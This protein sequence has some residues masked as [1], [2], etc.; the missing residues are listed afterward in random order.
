VPGE[1]AGRLRGLEAGVCSTT[2]V[3]ATRAARPLVQ[4]D[5]LA[6]MVAETE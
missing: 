4:S 5:S 2:T 1:C 6:L 3:T